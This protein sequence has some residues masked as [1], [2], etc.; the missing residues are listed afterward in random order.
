MIQVT[1]ERVGVDP[2]TDQAVVLLGDLTKTTFIPIWIRSVEASSIALPIQGIQPPRPLTADLVVS[3]V[4]SLG[5]QVVMVIISDIKDEVFYA[6]LVLSRGGEEIDIDCRP[7]DAVA[8][9][10]R[11]SVPIY[12]LERVMAQAGVPSEDS[13]VQ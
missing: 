9:A 2:E 11:K 6:T 13:A 8:V 3:V 5:A 1:V 7:S 12:V 4:E 10:L